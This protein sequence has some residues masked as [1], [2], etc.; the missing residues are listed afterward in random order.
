[1]A[2]RIL[3]H[4]LPPIALLLALAGWAGEITPDEAI[5]HG[6]KFVEAVGWVDPNDVTVTRVD[7]ARLMIVKQKD[8][9]RQALPPRSRLAWVVRCVEVRKVMEGFATLCKL[10]S[11]GMSRPPRPRRPPRKGLEEHIAEIRVDAGSGE[12]I[13]Q[14]MS[15]GKIRWLTKNK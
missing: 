8:Y 5:D 3:H 2:Y 12:I 15:W 11:K 7:S 9:S 13:G 6:R 1:M 4:L 14:F 10:R